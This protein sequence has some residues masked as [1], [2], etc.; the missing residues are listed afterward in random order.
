MTNHVGWSTSSAASEAARAALEAHGSAVDALI[1]GYFALAGHDE[2]AL[3]APASA[4]VAGVGAGARAFDGRGLQAGRGAPRPRGLTS[5][6]APAR[7]CASIPRTLELVSLLAAGRTRTSMRELAARGVAAARAHGA[8]RRAALLLRVAEAGPLA[9]RSESAI[10][11]I[12]RVAGPNAGGMI[13]RDDLTTVVPDEVDATVLTGSA[14]TG[15]RVPVAME[16]WAAI[17][18][19]PGE[20]IGAEGGRLEL[21]LAV[22]DWGTIGALALHTRPMTTSRSIEE[23]DLR[24]PEFEVSLPLAGVP[25]RR[26]EPRVTPGTVLPIAPSI[27]AVDCGPELRFALGCASGRALPR[28]TL[29]Q[30]LGERPLDR[31]LASLT[32]DVP[33]FAAIAEAHA[34]RSWPA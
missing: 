26:G 30:L 7:A 31:A 2:G 14:V 29:H 6:A 17:D 19:P 32:A 1:A 33:V 23:S 10:E 15:E 5:V 21:V 3:L 22:D 16:P 27:A 4:L 18:A 28:E 9:M 12:L 20:G 13:T 24:V 8:E 34:G 11:A 25:V